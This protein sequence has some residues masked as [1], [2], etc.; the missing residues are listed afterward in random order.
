MA[1]GAAGAVVALPSA[2]QYPLPLVNLLSPQV[3]GI[4]WGGMNG[5]LYYVCL[6]HTTC[7]LLPLISPL[8]AR[9]PLQPLRG[10]GRRGLPD[11]RLLLQP[12][13]VDVGAGAR[14]ESLEMLRLPSATVTPLQPLAI[15][16]D[17]LG[18]NHANTHIVRQPLCAARVLRANFSPPII[19]CSPRSLA[20]RAALS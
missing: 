16:V 19:E 17:D 8:I 11:G 15:G 6:P 5:A 12:L 20:T 9:R 7:T 13:V 1:G 10:D 3:L 18:G 4:E 2:D 14:G